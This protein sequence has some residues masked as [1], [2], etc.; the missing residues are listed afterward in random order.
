MMNFIFE[1]CISVWD[2]PPIKCLQINEV[3]VS[4]SYTF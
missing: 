3:I 4:F 2:F 1:N